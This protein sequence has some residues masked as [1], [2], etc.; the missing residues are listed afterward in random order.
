[1][2]ELAAKVLELARS[3]GRTV[4]IPQ[5]N[6]R[7]EWERRVR[8]SSLRPGPRLVGLSLLQRTN[9]EHLVSWAS[10]ATLAAD[11]GYKPRTIRRHLRTLRSTG[12]LY[13]VP[14]DRKTSPLGAGRGART[15]VYLY[16][17]APPD[18]PR[19]NQPDLPR[20]SAPKAPPSTS[21]TTLDK[22]SS[23]SSP[24]TSATTRAP[25]VLVRFGVSDEQLHAALPSLVSPASSERG[26]APA[27][28][29]VD[30]LDA[31]IA[32][33]PRFNATTAAEL[34]RYS[35]SKVGPA[36]GLAV[37]QAALAGL[38]S[39]IA[40]EQSVPGA[41]SGSPRRVAARARKKID[42]EADRPIAAGAAGAPLDLEPLPGPA[43]LAQA[44]EQAR[45]GLRALLGAIETTGPPPARGGQR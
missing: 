28:I 43:E 2:I 42:D 12:D 31:V 18:A 20:A 44:H 16:T 9:E 7:W 22:S 10:I 30:L 6:P 29:P 32:C 11:T 25:G 26:T 33:H 14:R 19:A 1:M 35:R 8:R 4:E 15:N 21:S 24:A 37:A 39:E 27:A 3:E 40:V 45:A 41:R 13:V 36:R 23:S 17:P 5:G 38:R 34:L